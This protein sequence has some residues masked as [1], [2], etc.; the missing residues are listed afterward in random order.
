MELK[1]NEGKLEDYSISQASLDQILMELND[2][3]SV[4]LVDSDTS[5]DSDEDKETNTVSRKPSQKNVVKEKAKEDAKNKEKTE[6]KRKKEENKK[7]GN[8][9][10]EKPIKKRPPTSSES[11][12]SDEFVPEKSE[13][14]KRWF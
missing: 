6:Q 11:T 4:V 14:P 1:R 10:S 9:K 12:D 5:E 13:E 2:V 8:K 3:D 7:K